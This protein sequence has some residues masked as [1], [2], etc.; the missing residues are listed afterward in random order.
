VKM[1]GTTLGH[2]RIVEKIGEFRCQAQRFNDFARMAE[3]AIC[4]DGRGYS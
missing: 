3:E 4:R 1:I 2:Y